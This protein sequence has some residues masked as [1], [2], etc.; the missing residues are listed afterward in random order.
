MIYL[1]FLENPY[2]CNPEYWIFHNY[3][4]ELNSSTYWSDLYFYRVKNSEIIEEISRN[5]LCET[6]QILYTDLKVFGYIISLSR[7][8]EYK[9]FVVSYLFPSPLSRRCHFGENAKVMDL[10]DILR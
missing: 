5:S 3:S 9:F 7:K 2:I 6:C 4:E 1:F 10:R 8:L